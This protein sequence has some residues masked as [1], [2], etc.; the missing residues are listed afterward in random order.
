MFLLLDIVPLDSFLTPFCSRRYRFLTTR[1][2]QTSKSSHSVSSLSFISSKDRLP[3][4]REF[5]SRFT[6]LYVR[7][8]LC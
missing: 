1:R 8:T 7:Y 4:D 3:V 5:L 6:S 2:V